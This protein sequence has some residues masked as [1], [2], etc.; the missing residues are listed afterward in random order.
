MQIKYHDAVAKMIR[1]VEH[2]T[3]MLPKWPKLQIIANMDGKST[4]EKINKMDVYIWKKDY[5]LL[6]QQKVEFKEK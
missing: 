1:E 6:H 2:L 3:F 4:Q 5:E